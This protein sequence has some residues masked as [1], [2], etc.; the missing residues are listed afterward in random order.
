LPLL[1]TIDSAA[2]PDL[3][4]HLAPFAREATTIAALRPADTSAV[5]DA[6]YYLASWPAAT[7][8]N[9]RAEHDTLAQQGVLQRLAARPLSPPGPTLPNGCAKTLD[10]FAVPPSG[11]F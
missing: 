4:R 11:A 7:Q 1:K 9:L 2:L 5:S 8:S 3:G 6:F 10:A